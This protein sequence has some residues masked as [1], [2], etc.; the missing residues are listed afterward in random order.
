[1]VTLRHPAVRQSA[2]AG[3]RDASWGEAVAAVM[4]LKPGAVLHT[5]EVLLLCRNKLGAC[6]VPGTVTW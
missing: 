5:E 6:K 2:A 4:V 1:M 3:D